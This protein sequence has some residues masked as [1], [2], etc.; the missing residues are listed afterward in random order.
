MK[1]ARKKKLC[2][3]FNK[4]R[5]TWNH[6]WF[7]GGRRHSVKLGTLPELPTREE[8]INRAVELQRQR[9]LQKERSVPTVTELVDHYRAEKMPTRRDTRGGYESWLRVYILPKWRD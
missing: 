8:A 5:S 7:E 6:L 3:V 2:V 4:A 9:R 1:R